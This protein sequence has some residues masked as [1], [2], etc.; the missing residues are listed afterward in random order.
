MQRT[1][2]Y[3]AVLVGESKP[4]E[5][6][7][8]DFLNETILVEKSGRLENHDYEHLIQWTGL[9]DKNGV[10]IYEG[11][12]VHYLYKPGEGFWNADCKATISWKNT[13]FHIAPFSGN[14]MTGWLNSIPGAYP[15][16]CE[17]LFEIIG[18]IY[19]NPEL[20]NSSGA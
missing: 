4:R 19:E 7:G 3:R 13:G 14:G 5:V 17:K 1:I 10:E 12:I 11:D 15:G 6:H 16:A 20:L 18:N 8:I 9:H 2:K